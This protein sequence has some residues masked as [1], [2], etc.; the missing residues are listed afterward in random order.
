MNFNAVAFRY[1]SRLR[2]ERSRSMHC[3]VPE[4]L[5]T[6]LPHETVAPLGTVPAS[7]PARG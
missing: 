2:I 1:K 4:A 3:E 6:E 7:G 5:V